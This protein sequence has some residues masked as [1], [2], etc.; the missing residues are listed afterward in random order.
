MEEL[1]VG[2]DEDRWARVAD[3]VRLSEM[4]LGV[5]RVGFNVEGGDLCG[6]LHKERR[7]RVEDGL[8]GRGE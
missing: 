6:F 8:G 1:W 5:R 2:G 3:G 4:V 7:V